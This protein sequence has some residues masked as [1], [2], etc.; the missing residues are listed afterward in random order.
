MF[1][2]P[3][4]LDQY[5]PA[6]V[7]EAAASGRLGLDHRFLHSLLDRRE[8]ALPALLAFAER[9][10]SADT[11]DLALE[12]IAIFRAWKTFEAIP[13]FIRY[14]KED[15][16]DL[17]DELM[18]ALV[19][20]GRP[21]LEPLL[22]LYHELDESES[23]E[24]AFVL[25]HLRVRDARIRKILLERLEYDL[26]DT[27]LLLGI[28]GDPAA[29]SALENALADLSE[30]DAELKQEIMQVI[31][32][33]DEP[34]TVIDDKTP[35]FDIWQLYPEEADLPVD[36]LDP[37]A[38][39]ELLNHPVASVRAVAAASFFNREVNAKERNKL[40]E[41]AQRDES[42]TVR[43]HSWEALMGATEN[44]EV[45]DAMLAAM[46]RP[47][48]DMEERG[49]VVVGLASEVDRNE[50]RQAILDLYERPEGRAKAMEAMWRSLHPSF[51]DNFAKHLDDADLE[52]R[53]AAIW[54]IGYYGLR[55]ELDRLRKFLD[56]EDLRSDALFA[57]ALAIPA[58]ISRGRLKGL[59]ARIEK[60]A[61]GFSEAEEELVKTALDERLMLAGKEP[62]FLAQED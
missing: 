14:S 48:L 31:A 21:A 46:R 24:I 13:F 5:S 50:V 37:D 39:S 40:L 17:P 2:D 59:L 16:L 53:R 45:V 18:E 10:R 4:K 58:E 11:V 43:A 36:L 32:G 62:V 47:D 51:R 12:L 49:G 19:E 1:L 56:D 34:Q 60:D 41:L 9:D 27:T 3:G 33:L 29:K 61:K 55:S 57:Y 25:T 28:Y 20:M 35:E 15:P 54:G 52:V 26:S 23:G 6:E 38:R 8:E 44:V 42:A 22:T 30:S 7:L